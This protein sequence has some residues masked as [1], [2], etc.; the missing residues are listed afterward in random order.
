MP[1]QSNGNSI[2][3]A[4]ALF[5]QNLAKYPIEEQLAV[6]LIAENVLNGC[7]WEFV[8]RNPELV[9]NLEAFKNSK[10]C[11]I[12]EVTYN[13]KTRQTGYLVS[14]KLDYLL[15]LLRK[16]APGLIDA[17]DLER[18]AKHHQEAIYKL[19]DTMKK[20]YRGRIGVYC[21]NDSS[22]ITV[23][24]ETSPA[25]AI[26]LM[27]LLQVCVKAGYGID[28]DGQVRSP[29][30]VYQHFNEVLKACTVAPSSNAIL[31]K[32]APMK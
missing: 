17:R 13:H 31:I 16:E 26:T 8:R 9:K 18:A 11:S 20:K 23:N 14:M 22:S 24:G 12:Q 4:A 2:E 1:N 21:T 28:I 3:K 15:N 7:S 19:A 6:E 32:I 5:N 29:D 25:F 30:A 10:N 27:E